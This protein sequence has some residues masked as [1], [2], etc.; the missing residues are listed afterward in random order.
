MALANFKDFYVEHSPLI[1]IQF[2]FGLLERT[3][4]TDPYTIVSVELFV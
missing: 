1:S 2:Q 3:T 4:R